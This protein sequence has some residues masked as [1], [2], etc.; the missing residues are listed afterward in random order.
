MGCVD[1]GPT[2][3]TELLRG[4]GAVWR[5]PAVSK[6]LGHRQGVS[7]D[8]AYGSPCPTIRGTPRSFLCKE[9]TGANLLGYP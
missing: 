6:L 5:H 4:T 3:R 9:Q 8:A 1:A 7:M 2:K